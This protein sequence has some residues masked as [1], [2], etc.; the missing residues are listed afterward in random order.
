MNA[1]RDECV[2][3]GFREKRRKTTP[4]QT[5]PPHDACQLVMQAASL[6]PPQLQRRQIISNNINQATSKHHHSPYTRVGSAPQQ[7]TLVAGRKQTQK[8]THHNRSP[9]LSYSTGKTTRRNCYYMLYV[10]IMY[11]VSTHV[12]GRGNLLGRS[13]R[14][15][16]PVAH[17]CKQHSHMYMRTC[18]P[19]DRAAKHTYP[20]SEAKHARSILYDGTTLALHSNVSNA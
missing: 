9:T 18:V 20:G 11:V 17:A 3:A 6:L 13:H 8:H 14:H 10:Y 19:V 7:T 16:R 1:S 5:T 12:Q 4:P 15:A 2:S